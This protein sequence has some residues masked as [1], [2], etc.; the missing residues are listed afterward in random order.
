WG[1]DLARDL[2]DWRAGRITWAEVDR[3]IL[4][5]GPPGTGKTTFAAALA[6]SCRAHFVAGSLSKWQAHGHLG[7]FLRAMRR[8]FEEAKK[9]A[10][11]ILFID[12]LDSVGDRA[13]FSGDN[14]SYCVQVV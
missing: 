9:N 5:S 10:P 6:R 3:G 14:R 4:L 13:Q 8:A 11:S 12:E 2:D 7:D 1:R